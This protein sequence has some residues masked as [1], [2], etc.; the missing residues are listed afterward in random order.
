[1]S[2]SG[3][4]AKN[5]L[6]QPFDK[7]SSGFVR[8]EACCVIYLQKVENAKRIYATIVNSKTNNDGFKR[9]GPMVPSANVQM[10]LYES[11]YD[12]VNFDINLIDYIEAHATSTQLGD[13]QELRSLDQ[14][15]CKNR[16]IPLK[17]GSV[18]SNMG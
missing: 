11:V 14:F 12:N 6:S 8:A 9:D 2:R 5:G 17:I 15:F 1:M 4:L 3:V 13:K 16:K 10:K 18:K 7:N